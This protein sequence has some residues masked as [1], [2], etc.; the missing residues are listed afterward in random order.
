MRLPIY[1]EKDGW[2]L[3]IC[4]KCGRVNYCE[5]H[6]LT[7]ECACSNTWTTHLGIPWALRLGAGGHLVEVGRDHRLVGK[8]RRGKPL[9]TTGRAFQFIKQYYTGSQVIRAIRN[10]RVRHGVGLRVA[11]ARIAKLVRLS[12]LIDRQLGALLR[13]KS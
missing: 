4:S 10:Y 12:D 9:I 11:I 6:G 7:A 5:P 13:G 2:I 1:R 8:P 3:T